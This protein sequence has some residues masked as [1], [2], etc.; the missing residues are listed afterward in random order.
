MK[1]EKQRVRV[2]VDTGGTFTDFVYVSGGRARVFK[3]P[4]TPDDPSRAIVEGLRRVARESGVGVRER[5]AADGSVVEEL[6][7]GEVASLVAKLKRAR[8]E[9]V[10]VCLLFSFARPEH[11]RRIESALKDALEGVP[12]S[13]SH[14]ILPEYR[15][16]ERTST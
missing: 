2:G 8:A 11:E 7:D 12:L 13:V 4:S 15:E 3:V 6:T 16:F 1:R 9:S 5:V 14:R 10:A